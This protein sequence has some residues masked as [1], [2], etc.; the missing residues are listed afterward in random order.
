[1]KSRYGE[2]NLPGFHCAPISGAGI[3]LFA[4]IVSGKAIAKM[5]R[6]PRFRIAIEK[7][8]MKRLRF[9]GILIV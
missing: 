4:T 3:A 1:V 2:E 9:A 5:K 8:M 6:F 7:K